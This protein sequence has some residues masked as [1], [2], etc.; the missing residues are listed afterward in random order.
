MNYYEVLGV[1]PDSSQQQIRYAYRNLVLT[2][3]PDA[4]GDHDQFVKINQA[5]ETL[6]NVSKR[7]QYDQ[8]IFNVDTEYTED[9]YVKLK[10]S[11]A[12]LYGIQKHTL[13]IQ[14]NNQTYTVYIDIPI[15]VL[16]GEV[17][18]YKSLIKQKS[19][20]TPPSD[21]YV[22]VNI[23][24]SQQFVRVEY[25]LSTKLIIS[26]LELITGCVKYLKLPNGENLNVTIPKC[27]QPESVITVTGYGL[28]K[29]N[30]EFGNIYI[31]LDCRTPIIDCKD[32]LTMIE[33]INETI[34]IS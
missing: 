2:H 18:K 1:D 17:I 25:D 6:K 16:H 3:H 19:T 12:D 10:L 9:V 28:P 31:L 22:T 26:T 14:L 4:A 29:K 5:Y 20:K 13:D 27:T 32:T 8:T 7:R 33:K 23:L 24:D 34:T 21:L 11:L 30:G 15:G